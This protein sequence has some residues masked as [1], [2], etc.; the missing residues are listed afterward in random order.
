MYKRLSLM[1]FFFTT[2]HYTITASKTEIVT[3]ER[4][5]FFL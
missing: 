4:G 5:H 1:L 3:S 2:K